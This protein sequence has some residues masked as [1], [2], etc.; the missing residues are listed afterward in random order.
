VLCLGSNT[1]LLRVFGHCPA[2]TVSLICGVGLSL[3][4]A[5]CT[6]W[7]LSLLRVQNSLRPSASSYI[8]W[9]GSI[10]WAAL[11]QS[12]CLS[13]LMATRDAVTPLKIIGLAAL[14]NVVGDSLLC[15]WPWRLGCAGAAAATAVATLTSCGAMLR[16]LSRKKLLPAVR[17]PA[18]REIMGLLEFTG[19]L[20][21]I[22]LTRMGG[23]IAMQRTAMKLGVQSLAGY[24]LCI[25]LLMFF[26]L[27]GEP[28]SQLS[29]TQLPAL[30]DRGDGLAVTATLRSILTLAGYTSLGVAAVAYGVAMFGSAMI[31]SDVAVQ[32]VARTAA[33]ALFCHVGF[34]RLWFFAQDWTVNLSHATYALV[35]LQF[36][37]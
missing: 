7:L 13:T 36:R 33:P 21:A 24:Q 29:Q 9:R 30:L 16:A 32:L 1:S 27:F 4:F 12:V 23:I 6:P 8:Y 5:L 2:L 19:P 14:V 34:S 26:V 11:A 20:L 31:S 10:A 17:I 37:Q 28:L 35:L 3:A 15:V 25:N 22:T 18:R